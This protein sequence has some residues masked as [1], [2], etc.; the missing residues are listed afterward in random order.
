MENMWLMAQSLGIGF[1][2]MSVCSEASIETK[3]KRVLNIP[4]QLKIAYACRLGYPVSAAAQYL[5]VRR[6]LEDFT[7]ANRFGDTA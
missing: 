1:M 5:R 7:H 4:Q 3:I 2:V 6:D